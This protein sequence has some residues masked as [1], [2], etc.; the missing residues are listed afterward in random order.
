MNTSSR[1]LS[2]FAS[3][4]VAAR[5]G[6]ANA[7][8]RTCSH[9][10]PVMRTHNAVKMCSGEPA[11]TSREREEPATCADL[12]ASRVSALRG[13]RLVIGITSSPDKWG[14]RRREGI[15]Q[16]WLRYDQNGRQTLACFVL[17]R[18]GVKPKELARIDAEAALRGDIIFLRATADGQGP[19]VTISKLHAWFRLASELL[20][21]IDSG[22]GGGVESSAGGAGP[23]SEAEAMRLRPDSPR[24]AISDYAVAM[25]H[26][27][28]HI[29]K[30]DDDTFI[31]LPELHRELDAM[32]CVRNLYYGCLCYSGYNPISFTKCGFDYGPNGGRYRK[33]NCASDSATHGAAHPPFPWTSGAVM[34]ASTPLIARIAADPAIGSFVARSADPSGPHQPNMRPGHNTD[35]DVA[36]G[37]WLSRFHR[38]GVAPVTYVKANEKLTNIGCKLMN[39]L[40]RPPR[41]KSVGVHFVKTA[42]GME[43]VWGMLVRGEKHNATRCHMMT[44]DYR[45]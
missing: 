38:S 3:V 26:S 43:Y 17:G 33:Y 15:R 36:M 32:H 2:H 39:G 12:R 21:L 40:Y 34:L 13:V 28:R 7:E 37:F 20:G 5:D 4:H 1:Y 9:V 8:S 25:A 16:T 30:I 44:G 42:G 18:R 14:A 31:H 10:F 41:N 19:F 11:F 27:V 6:D 29:A 23:L 45:L 24:R 35:E 22:S